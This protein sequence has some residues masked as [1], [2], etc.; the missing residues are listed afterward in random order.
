M[1]KLGWGAYSTVWLAQKT[2]PS[3][4]FV[5]VKVT[6]ADDG[7][8]LTKE[9][10]MLEKAQTKEGNPPHVLTLLDSFT[11]RGPNGAH[12]V[13]VTDI[14]VS[15]SSLLY[16][17]R[18]R[19]QFWHKNAA[20]GLTQALASLYATGIGHGGTR[21]LAFI[22]DTAHSP[23]DLHIGNFGFAFPQIADQDPYNVMLD[24]DDHERIIVLLTACLCP[25]S[26]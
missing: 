10:A 25:R 6:M 18:A 1:H 3:Q 19:G 21:S 7:I 26:M 8:D 2:D 16:R 14:V 12:F 5:A 4:A 24:L 15:M 20:R 23:L 9:A 13:L 11:L 22:K 17:N